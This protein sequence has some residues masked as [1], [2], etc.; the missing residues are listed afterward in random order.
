[1]SQLFQDVRLSLRRMRREPV[2]TS[3]VV[4]TLALAIGATTAVFSLVYQV[5]LKPLPYPEPQELLRLYPS[6]PQ[7][8]RGGVAYAYLQAWRERPGAFQ[9]IG[10]GC[11]TAWTP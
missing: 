8:E 5:L 6:T 10:R 9:A 11:S 2:F 7:R 4:A 3:V 1:M